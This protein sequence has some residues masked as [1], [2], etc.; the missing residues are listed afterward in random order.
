VVK[1]L[2]DNAIDA[3]SSRVDVELEEGGLGLIACATTAA[4]STRTTCC[5]R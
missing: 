1:E 3:G 2:V 4:A 5:W